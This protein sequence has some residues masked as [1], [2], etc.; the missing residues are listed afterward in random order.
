M[1]VALV[2]VQAEPLKGRDCLSLADWKPEEIGLILDVAQRLKEKQRRGERYTPLAGKT[3]AMIFDKPST[4]TRVSFETGIAQLGGYAL[5]LN[6][7]ELQMG[8]GET[9]ADTARV[10]SRYV[11]GILIRTFGHRTVVELARYAE[12]PV[13]NGLTDLHHPCQVLADLLTLREKKG[14]LAGLKLAFVGDGN[15]VAHS[16]L[17]GCAAMGVHISVAAPEGYQP[18]PDVVEEA[19]QIAKDTGAE[20]TITTDPAEAVQQAD[21][22][23]TDVWASMGQEEEKELRKQIFGSYQVDAKLMSKAKPDAVFLHCLPAYRGW[24]VTAD[25]LDGPQSV[26]WDQAENRLHAQKAL[27]LLLMG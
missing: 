13:I 15:N 3:L 23:Y 22:V 1:S 12:V 27:M 21:A 8:R 7:N 11:D 26:V 5:S 9:I 25:V 10:L 24:E 20:I 14:T 6:R 19:R 2:P 4:R 16:L 18:L 17:H